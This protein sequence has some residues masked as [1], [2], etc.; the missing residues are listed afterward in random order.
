[1]IS[2]TQLLLLHGY[3]FVFFYLFAVGIGLPIPADPLLLIMG[4]LVGDHHY[5]FVLAFLAALVPAVSAD[6]IWYEIGRYKGTSALRLLCR[7][8]IEPDTCVRSAENTFTKRGIATLYFAKFVPGLSL[9]SMPMA[10]VI[11]M[12]RRRFL[13]ADTIGCV[14]WI[15]AYMLTGVLF[16]RYVESLI[17]QIGF[18]GQRAGVVIITLL[19]LYVGFK[20]I[21]RWRILRELRVN[22]ITPLAVRDL[23]DAS[24][25]SL[26]IV[27]LRHPSEVARDAFKI[28]GALVLKPE[29]L[30]AL[31]R[32]IPPEQEIILYCT[33]PNEA[34]SAR[35][36]L[37]LKKAG[38]R[39]VRPLEGG[40]AAWRGHG[41]PIEDIP[42]D[43]DV[44]IIGNPEPPVT[45][46]STDSRAE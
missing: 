20:Y 45:S 25:N 46:L 7:L 28:P 26:T 24:K 30:R 33:R 44:A 22:R 27:D 13:I 8:T 14:L 15:A 1:M 35:V 31:A 37:Q 12:S 3:Y 4:A 17:V 29:E 5:N 6:V 39:R 2:F 40:L 34:T 21:Q 41:F 9:I 32:E 36:A 38:F 16:H 11:G 42:R 19:L 23:L 18:F 43:I 10:G